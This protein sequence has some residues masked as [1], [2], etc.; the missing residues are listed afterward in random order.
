M[1]TKHDAFISYSHQSDSKLAKAIEEGIERLAKPLLRLRACDVFRDETSLAAN[2]SLWTGIADNLSGSEWFLLLACPESASSPW[3]TKETAHWLENR[4]LQRMLIVWTGGDLVWSAEARDFDWSATSSLNPAL[5]GKFPD[6]PLYVDLRWARQAESLTLADLKFRDAVLNLAAPVRSM[7]KDELDGA[8]VRQ[9]RRNRRLVQIGVSAI[10]LA[11]VV[12][13]WQA[14]VATRERNEAVRQTR[15][16]LSRSLTSTARQRLETN[17]DQALLLATQAVR[18]DASNATRSALLAAVQAHPALQRVVRPGSRVYAGVFSPDGTKYAAVDVGGRISIWD[19]NTWHQVREIP[20]AHGDEIWAVAFV[21]AGG[22]LVTASLDKTLAVWDVESGK[23]VGRR[24][25]GHQNQVLCAAVSSDGRMAAS[26]DLDGMIRVW[27]L[28]TQ[29][30]VWTIGK[31]HVGGV[32]SVAFSPDRRLLVSGGFDGEIRAWSA[33]DGRVTKGPSKAQQGT[34]MRLA[35]RHDGAWLASADDAGTIRFWDTSTWK[36]AARPFRDFKGEIGGLSFSPD[37]KRLA[38]GGWDGQ[39]KLWDLGPEDEIVTRVFRLHQNQVWQVAF[40]PDGK[41]LAS[42]SWDGTVALWDTTGWASFP[43]EL[44]GYTGEAFTLAFSPRSDVVA[45]GDEAGKVYLHGVPGGERAAN[46]LCGR[47]EGVTALRFSPSGSL[48]A[49]GGVDGTVMLWDMRDARPL[50]W[51]KKIGDRMIWSLAF[52]PDEAIVVSAADGGNVARWDVKTGSAAQVGSGAL[53]Y[54]PVAYAPDWKSFVSSTKDGDLVLWDAGTT[55][56]LRVLHKRGGEGSP[57]SAVSFSP[58]GRRLAASIGPRQYVWSVGQWDSF[59]TYTA[60]NASD[61]GFTSDSQ[62]LA[63]AQEGGE[64]VLVDV[65]SKEQLPDPLALPR[66]ATRIAFSSHGMRLGAAFGASG[67]SPLIWN[68]DVDALMKRACQV[69]NRDLT[70]VEWK[71][72]A[73]PLPQPRIC[74][75]ETP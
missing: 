15:I 48:L 70:A 37:G 62:T 67:F 33:S 71:E 36:E 14:I 16:A 17:P 32:R 39:V 7:R 20:E 13:V 72:L 45:I 57:P 46:E 24:M 60:G 5:K 38:A 3:C 4:S 50:L 61:V 19:T 21:P 12:A 64:I 18:L 47:R 42:A 69:A 74:P 23:I 11:A 34:V 43:Q 8:D 41:T 2:P 73:G 63:V 58:D 26:G 22:H 25:I 10:V 53:P 31:A 75:S 59:D 27:D 55:T 28:N 9:L 35:F 56:Q 6:E 52:T 30:P 54:V 44:N 68:L 51:K 49:C 1:T 65:E 29:E 66:S 40:H